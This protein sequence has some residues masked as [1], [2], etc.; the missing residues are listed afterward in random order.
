[1]QQE[2][3]DHLD[4]EEAHATAAQPSAAGRAKGETHPMPA[5]P[6]AGG[7]TRADQP[8][9]AG[10][11]PRER[12]RRR[13]QGDASHVQPRRRVRGLEKRGEQAGRLRFP[14]EKQE[15]VRRGIQILQLYSK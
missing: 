5:V 10:Q 2:L 11:A 15:P 6:E 4:Q 13:C 8:R 12:A 14:E 3:L 7:K 1:M 9:R